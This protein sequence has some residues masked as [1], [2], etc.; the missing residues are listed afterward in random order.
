MNM[1][2][3]GIIAGLILIA[4]GLIG[5]FGSE[6][7]STTAFIPAYAGLAILLS[8]LLAKN[9]RFLKLGMHLAAVF[10]LL[11]FLAPLGRLVR[12]MATGGLT[13]DLSTFCVIG[14]ALVCAIFTWQCILSFRQVRRDRLRS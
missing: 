4:I 1:P 3:K 2:R 7:K 14:M 11:G 13:W 5:Y 9:P 12:K 6:V 10:G 8:S